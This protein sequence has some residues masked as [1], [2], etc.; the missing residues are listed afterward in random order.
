M[1][2]THAH[3]TIR[4]QVY[5]HLEPTAWTRRGLS[6]INRFICGLIVVSAALAIIET[7]PEISRAYRRMFLLMEWLAAAVFAVEYAAR[8][9][10][11]VENPKYGE[12]WRGRLRYVVSPLALVDLV[13]LLPV[14]ML[15]GGTETMLLRTFRLLRI[16][17]VARLGR[18]SRAA[19]RIVDAVRSR[20]Y[21]LGV[22]VCT[23]IFLLI[24]S[25]TLLYLV[26][27]DV[28]PKAF[29]SIPRSMWWSIVTLT[30]VGYGDVFPITPLGRILA[31][32]TAIMGIGLI[33][34]PTGI[35]A[36]A[37]SEAIRQQERDNERQDSDPR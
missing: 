8:L 16:V 32:I 34:M 15:V 10:V 20:R 13:A 35:L 17:R 30:T 33:A 27:G 22:S 18:F 3:P 23:A 25:S 11:C 26:E 28:Q 19:Q 4:R 9:W 36:A 7:E 37:F 29:G 31:A 2:T 24:V 6:L 14:L 1:D 21:E 5:I 12:G